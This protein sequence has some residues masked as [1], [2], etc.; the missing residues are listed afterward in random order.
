VT[1]K[2]QSKPAPG[3]PGPWWTRRP[4]YLPRGRV[5]W[6]VFILILVVAFLGYDWFRLSS[7]SSYRYAGQGWKFPT[8]VY[9]DWRDYR[10]GDHVNTAAVQRALD[11]ARYRRIWKRPTDPGQYRV[12]GAT[13]EIC[14]RPFTYP[15]HVERGSE[16]AIAIQDNKVASLNEGFSEPR[17]RGLLR[18]D[19]EILGE[20]SD[21]ARERRSYIP[22]GLMPRHLI[23]AVVA[24]EDRRFFRHW[25]LDLLGMG[26]ATVRNVRAGALVEGGST[27][28]QQ[29]VKNLFL[30]RDRNVWRKFHEALLAL[31]VELRYSKEQILEFYL[32]QIYLGQRGSWSVCGVEEG[33]LY[34][35]NKHVREVTPAEAA[36]LVGVIPAPNKLSPYRDPDAALERRDQVLTDMVECGFISKQ[37]AARYRQTSLRFA[38]NAPPA[39]RAPYFIDYVRELLAKDISES[40]LSA[41][42]FSIFTTLDGRMQEEAERIVRSGAREADWRS[43]TGGAERSPAQASLV[44]IEPS[45]GYIRAMV[46]GRNYAESPYNR[47]VDSRRQPGSAFKPFVYAAALDSYYSG[48]RPV[49]TGATLLRD[50]PDTFQTN[51]GPWAPKNFENAY[52]GQVTTARALA[53]SLNV[54]TVRLSQLVGLPKVIEM[55][56]SLGIE[57]RLRQVASLALGT[58]ELSVLELTTAYAT[59][60][61]GGVRVPPLAV[62]A[63]LDRGG[64][65]RWSPRRESRRVIRPETA[66]MTTILLEGPVIYGTASAVRSAYGFTRPAA[67]KTG[68]TDDE[69]DAWFIGYSPDLAAGV[70]VGC[71]RNRR[72]GLT[73]TQAAVP[74]WARFMQT[75]LQDR[76]FRD[77]E[78]PQDVVD[79]WIDGD[80]GYRAGP[81]C[82]HVMRAAFVRKTEPRQMC[83]VMHLP[84]W[85]DSLPPD[86]TRYEEPQAPEETP[87]QEREPPAETAPN[88]SPKPSGDGAGA[89]GAGVVEPGN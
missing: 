1:D 3:E 31:M 18:I 39:T 52:A 71:D 85:S 55:A 23:L 54:A 13:F 20:F 63:V 40:D 44:A 15:D 68:T 76:P 70:W 80:T 59:L 86:S 61:N 50:E 47:A 10:V 56:R 64:N 14:L 9:A 58:S 75:A 89:G 65:V 74:I 79:V 35:F 73:G 88:A 57:S 30:S 49:I 11:R 4:D 12:R 41:R 21:Q 5:R 84:F 45:T 51:L 22:L 27:I 67:G 38:A 66:Y 69:N 32:N 60:A 43:P 19:P 82:L 53:R 77:F 8:Q 7:L 37:D 72:I 28:S 81:E 33:S 29:L 87:G 42:G 62:K 36:L 48:K 24:S 26:R 34:Y 2:P 83:P 25:G 6:V 16:V 78:A 17:P 46:G